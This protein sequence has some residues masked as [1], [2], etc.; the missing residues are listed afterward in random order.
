[1]ENTDLTQLPGCESGIARAVC[2]LSRCCGFAD[3]E[4]GAPLHNM[5][6]CADDILCT[7]AGIRTLCCH[8]GP[9]LQENGTPHRPTDSIHNPKAHNGRCP[10]ET[11]FSPF[12]PFRI[13]HWLN[14]LR[15]Y[16]SCTLSFLLRPA[17]RGRSISA[18]AARRVQVS[19]FGRADLED[20]ALHP[21]F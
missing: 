13:P 5:C 3:S 7:H 20:L 14:P 4:Y 8:I 19:F 21:S 10:V 18:W 9:Y 15:W 16:F 2:I 11:I 6:L 1:M 12:P 17:M